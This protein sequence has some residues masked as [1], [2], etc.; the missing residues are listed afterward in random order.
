MKTRY[1]EFNLKLTI[2]KY[3]ENDNHKRFYL[4]LIL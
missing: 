4:H 3:R 2:K 1:L